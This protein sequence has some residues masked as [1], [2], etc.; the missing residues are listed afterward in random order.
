MNSY[1]IRHLHVSYIDMGPVSSVCHLGHQFANCSVI[2]LTECPPN[3]MQFDESCYIGD[4]VDK[5]YSDAEAFCEGFSWSGRGHVAS[6]S[7]RAAAYALGA[8]DTG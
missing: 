4:R 3:S 7:T 6:P 1:N 5:T 8:T 2:I